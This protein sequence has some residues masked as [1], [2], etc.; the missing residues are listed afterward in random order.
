MQGQE[1]KVDSVT[2]KKY[3]TVDVVKTYE[4]IVAKGS[5]NPELLEYL[6]NHYYNVHNIV[7]S[8]IYFDLLFTKCQRSKISAKAVAIYKTL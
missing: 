3:I 4:R 8:K 2:K 1:V 5:Y 6:G 7:K